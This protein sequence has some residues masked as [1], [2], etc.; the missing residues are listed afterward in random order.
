MQSFITK[1]VSD[2]NDHINEF[3]IQSIR[4]EMTKRINHQ[5]SSKKLNI[6]MVKNINNTLKQPKSNET[7]PISINRLSSNIINEWTIF[8]FQRFMQF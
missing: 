1:L 5:N 6:E 3:M 7:V 8:I 4:N 2:N